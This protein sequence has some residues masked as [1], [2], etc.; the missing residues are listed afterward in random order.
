MGDFTETYERARHSI[1]HITADNGI[2]L[3]DSTG[4]IVESHGRHYIMMAAHGVMTDPSM[5]GID[6]L[7]MHDDGAKGAGH[8]RSSG[9]L[10]VPAGVRSILFRFLPDDPTGGVLLDNVV[11]QDT[12]TTLFHDDFSTAVAVSPPGSPAAA[13][14]SPSHHP[15]AVAPGSA[16]PTAGR[17]PVQSPSAVSPTTPVSMRE[18][19][20]R[21]AGPSRAAIP[22]RPSPANPGAAI[23]AAL[24]AFSTK[25]KTQAKGEAK[26]EVPAKAQRTPG[27]ASPSHTPPGVAV[28]GRAG[29]HA[30]W[31]AVEGP[32]WYAVRYQGKDLGNALRVDEQAVQR[33]LSSMMELQL[34]LDEPATLQFDYKLEARAGTLVVGYR[35]ATPPVGGR[36]R[37]RAADSVSSVTPQ[38]PASRIS[39]RISA[40][41]G[42]EIHPVDV[43]GLDG[44]GDIAI[45][46]VADRAQLDLL[47]ALPFVA[48]SRRIPIATPIATIGNPLSI[49][50]E[51]VAVGVLRDNRYSL[52]TPLTAE[53]ILTCV[54]GHGGDSGGPYLL[55][56]GNVAGMLTFGYGGTDASTLNGGP[57]AR[58]LRHVLDTIVARYTGSDRP[59]GYIEY[60]KP[61]LGLELFAVDLSVIRELDLPMVGSAPAVPPSGYIVMNIADDS[62][63]A[64]KVQQLDVLLALTPDRPTTGDVATGS[65]RKDKKG[66]GE[67]VVSAE[68][69]DDRFPVGNFPGQSSPAALTWYLDPRQSI[70]LELRR[71]EQATGEWAPVCVGPVP[72]IPFPP[73]KDVPLGRLLSQRQPHALLHV[74]LAMK[75]SGD[76]TR[77][78]YAV[79]ASM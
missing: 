75:V 65:S 43:I 61:Y 35:L 23:L 27:V 5:W 4:F 67:G 71:F 57:S 16:R 29:L 78:R 28:P 17:S 10:H 79:S 47:P 73:A 37:A 70:T 30:K 64:G 50:A 58:V 31:S 12:R 49:D 55:Q 13:V 46:L 68:A 8:Y 45:G 20:T 52:P 14:T 33:G 69:P 38:S 19:L 59:P 21:G 48:D 72:L 32:S 34:P 2:G 77:R 3:V 44:K 66:A 41:L 56:D 15:E 62:P 42:G 53:A 60:Q 54:S 39:R 26:T 63:F 76:V 6:G 18:V 36:E 24:T 40:Y 7:L 74:P 51:S 25:A 22:P 1:V 11:V 9:V